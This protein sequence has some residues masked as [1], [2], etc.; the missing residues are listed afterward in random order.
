MLM[1]GHI[2]R[3][4]SSPLVFYFFILGGTNVYF[5]GEATYGDIGFIYDI[6]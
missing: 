2:S 3:I 6:T 5:S 4:D 1:Y